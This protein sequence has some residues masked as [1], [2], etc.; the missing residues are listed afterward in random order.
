MYCHRKRCTTTGE[1]EFQE[2]KYEIIVSEA[3]SVMN[4]AISDA[5]HDKQ[6]WKDTA[7]QFISKGQLLLA[8]VNELEASNMSTREISCKINQTHEGAQTT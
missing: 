2:L 5:D 6:T 3:L 4:D 1:V 7:L 8:K